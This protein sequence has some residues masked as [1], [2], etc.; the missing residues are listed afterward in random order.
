MRRLAATVVALV[1]VVGA[2]G[3]GPKTEAGDATKSAPPKVTLPPSPN[4]VEPKFVEKYA[5]E[6]TV[7][8]SHGD[9]IGYLLHHCET[10]GITVDGDR[11]EKGSTWVLDFADSV[12]VTARYVPPPA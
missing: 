1:V 3:C 7:L 12:I 8:C 5:D 11:L 2:S 9:V 6:H 10:L 4:M